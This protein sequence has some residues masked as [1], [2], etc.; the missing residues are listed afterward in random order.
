[1]RILLVDDNIEFLTVLGAFLEAE[2]RHEVVGKAL[3]GREALKM[4]QQVAPDVAIVDYDMPDLD[5]PETVR[6][7][8][9]A[10]PEIRTVMISGFLEHEYAGSSL[11]AGADGFV[12]KHRIEE[13]LLSVLQSLT[14]TARL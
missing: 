12:A 14:H 4:A 11:R 7:M 10:A 5:G 2:G 6:R 3:C 1:M 8:K 9:R 13:E